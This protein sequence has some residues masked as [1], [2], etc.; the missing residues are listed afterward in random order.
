MLLQTQALQRQIAYQWPNFKIDESALP[1]SQLSS[2]AWLFGTKPRDSTH[3]LWSKIQAANPDKREFSV[4]SF[5]QPLF[6]V[7]AIWK[8][9]GG[10]AED[11][12]H[13][14]PGN[15]MEV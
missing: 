3:A 1:Y 2:D 15:M 11:M 6:Y 4:Q 14:I 9:N 5:I 7:K 13:S 10:V 12:Y 8:G